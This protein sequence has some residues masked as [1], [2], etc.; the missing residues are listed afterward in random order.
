VLCQDCGFK[1]SGGSTVSSTHTD[2]WD[3]TYFQV[4]QHGKS[5]MKDLSLGLIIDGTIDNHLNLV[6]T[7]GE[8]V[9]ID[10]GSTARDFPSLEAYEY[11]VDDKGNMK[12]TLLLDRKEAT[13][14]DQ[15]GDLGRPET[16][17]PPQD[18]K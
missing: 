6:V 1:G 13:P 8:K 3:N 10:P 9:G 15:H 11:T 17:I 16:P 2:E 18:P 14:N 7:P 5:A 12:T 4:S